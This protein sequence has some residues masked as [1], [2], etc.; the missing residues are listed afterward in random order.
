MARIADAELV[1]NTDSHDPED[2][3]DPQRAVEFL[4]SLEFS[5]KEIDRIFENSKK[6]I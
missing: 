4:K 5:D 3:I 6:L 2:L 1:L